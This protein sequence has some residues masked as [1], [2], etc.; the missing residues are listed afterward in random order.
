M[1]IKIYQSQIR[2]TEEIGNVP[3]TAGMRISTEIPAAIGRASSEFLGSVKDFYVE[4]EK[5]K[6]ETEVLEKK[7]RS[8]MEM[9]MFQDY[10]KL[11][12]KH[13]KWKI[14]MKQINI[15]KNN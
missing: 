14:L 8:I 1:A 12:M 11:K 4:Q 7:K 15:I 5:I 10:Q 13:L 2:A 9:K 6:A 3:T